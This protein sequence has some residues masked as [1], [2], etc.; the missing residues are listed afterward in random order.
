MN[1]ISFKPGVSSIQLHTDHS[2]DETRFVL[3]GMTFEGKLVVVVHVELEDSMRII[4]AR[5]ATPRER[6][7]YEQG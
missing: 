7:D 6:K 4:S 2:E 5:E 1:G 3:V